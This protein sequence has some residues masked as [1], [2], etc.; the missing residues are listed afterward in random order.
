MKVKQIL[1]ICYG[2][3]IFPFVFPIWHL[4]CKRDKVSDGLREDYL[5]WHKLEY[6]ELKYVKNNKGKE[7]ES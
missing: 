2:W 4:A 3:L 6:E 1:R 5:F 7:D